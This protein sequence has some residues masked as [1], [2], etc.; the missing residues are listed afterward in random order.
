MKKISRLVWCIWC[1]HL[2]FMY[3]LSILSDRDHVSSDPVIWFTNGGMIVMT[4][5]F[6]FAV[7]LTFSNDGDILQYGMHTM[8]LSSFSG[9][10]YTVGYTVCTTDWFGIRTPLV[11]WEDWLVSGII[12]TWT[13]SRLT[14]MEHGQRVFSLFLYSLTI[15]LGCFAISLLSYGLFVLSLFCFFCL[16][17]RLV[18][19]YK[20][21]LV[22]VLYGLIPAMYSVCVFCPEYSQQVLFVTSAF[23]KT[24]VVTVV[25]E[26]EQQ[27]KTCHEEERRKHFVKY[28]F[29][30][31]RT[32]LNSIQIG[33][34]LLNDYNNTSIDIVS[35][36]QVACRHVHET[37]N[38]VLYV[39]QSEEKKWKLQTHPIS[40]SELI[41]NVKKTIQPVMDA[42]RIGAKW[43]VCNGA[44]DID[45]NKVSHILLNLV[46][47][48]VKFTQEGGQVSVTVTQKSDVFTI[49]VTDTGCGIS[50]VDQIKLFGNFS[51]VGLT[52]SSIGSGLGLYISRELAEFM[53]GS[54]DL[55]RSEV[56][57][58]STFE[59]RLPVG[60][61]PYT[62]NVQE[63][64][65]V[66]NVG[67][68]E[69]R[70]VLVVDDHDTNR[71]MLELLFKR[72]NIVVVDTASDGMT[73]LQKIASG[74]Q[75][76][77]ILL[78]NIMPGLTGPET[79]QKMRD[80]YHYS[81]LIIGVTGNV[82]RE[83]I[84]HFLGAGVDAVFSKPVKVSDVKALLQ[85]LEEH[86]SRSRR[87]EGLCIHFQEHNHTLEWGDVCKYI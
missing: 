79:C 68:V 74:Q 72:L 42:K 33:A 48:A 60:N 69:V 15:L 23:V 24:T 13:L 2:A 45:S 34:D 81:S 55:L 62:I 87:T 7:L 18:C 46:S 5:S 38:N 84:L 14:E 54:L 65:K 27:R 71:K 51:Q 37:L 52:N 10:W 83:D 77:L 66:G 80:T 67:N 36:I 26:M 86:G 44:V 12:H 47:N 40:I 58:G 20:N 53:G 25:Y 64:G 3:A 39:Y 49:S 85:F 9:V 43:T 6:G 11:L 75:Y 30:E 63:N 28:I 32:P 31:L 19:C 59:L 56:G 29:H 21:Q 57:V 70:K 76:D 16:I 8:L 4:V 61:C 22:S 17:K 1:W 78:D 73:A 41:L 35:A 50:S 82:L